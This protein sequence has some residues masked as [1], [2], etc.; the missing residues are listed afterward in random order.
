MITV[1][2]ATRTPDSE[3]S[4]GYGSSSTV[5]IESVAL[6]RGIIIVLMALDH[7]HDF[8]GAL[9]PRATDLATTTPPLFLTR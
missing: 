2:T 8:F 5:R 9:E 3:A 4:A 7:V 1:E 6:L